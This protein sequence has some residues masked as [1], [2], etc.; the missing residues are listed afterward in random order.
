MHVVPGGAGHVWFMWRVRCDPTRRPSAFLPA[1]YTSECV[2]SHLFIGWQKRWQ[3]DPQLQVCV[4]WW[5]MW[6]FDT[7][8]KLHTCF[9]LLPWCRSCTQP[10]LEILLFFC[11]TQFFTCKVLVECLT[12][13]FYYFVLCMWKMF[14]VLQHSNIILTT[15]RRGKEVTLEHFSMMD[16][17]PQIFYTFDFCHHHFILL[18]PKPCLQQAFKY[19]KW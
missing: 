11:A 7:G 14:D 12:E 6:W 5:Q 3:T 10:H 9:S 18:L 8:W 16:S 15:V 13:M 19:L 2:N 4:F 1:T 17:V